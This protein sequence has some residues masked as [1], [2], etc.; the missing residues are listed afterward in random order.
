MTGASALHSAAEDERP[1]WDW[2]PLEAL[3]A[4]EWESLCDGCG[5]CCLVKL[6]DE[7]TG[8]VHFTDI[9][10]RLFDTNTCRC[11]D[12]ARRRRRVRDCLKLTP[13]LARALAWLPPTCAYRLRAEGRPLAWWHPLVSGSAETVH[14][15]GISV[16]GRVAASERDVKLDDYPEHIVSWPTKVPRRAKPQNGR[17]APVRRTSRAGKGGC[18]PNAGLP[19]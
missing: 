2:K 14:A 10:C 13:D 11:G 16:R 17:D 15:A 3:D 9:A 19:K 8:A 1:F 4:A 7:D 6:E 5:R 18:R 12:Y